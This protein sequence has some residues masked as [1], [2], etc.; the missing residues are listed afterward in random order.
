[1]NRILSLFILIFGLLSI[2]C[3]RNGD[4]K[5]EEIPSPKDKL[6]PQGLEGSTDNKKLAEAN[7]RFSI[8]V[9]KVSAKKNREK[10]IFLSPFSISTA[11][12][13]TYAGAMNDTEKEMAKVL[14]W[15]E[16][17][18]LMHRSMGLIFSELI[19]KHKSDVFK[20]NIAN[21]LYLNKDKKLFS[22]FAQTNKESYAAGLELVDFEQTEASAQSINNWVSE[23]TQK[24]IPNL[25][26]ASDLTGAE[27]VLVNAI[28]FYGTWAN[29]FKE[30]NTQKD[31]FWLDTD[32]AELRDFMQ[33]EKRIGDTDYQ[34]PFAYTEDAD[35]QVLELPYNKGEGS[36]LIF[37][38]QKDSSN[39]GYDL[40]EKIE[41]LDYDNMMSLIGKLSPTQKHILKIK[42]PKWEQRSK[43]DMVQIMVA[44]GLSAP[45]SP[46]ADFSRISPDFNPEISAIIHEAVI[47]VSEKGTKAAASTA[48]ITKETAV[49]IDPES[50]VEFY[51][52]RPF[53]YLIREKESGIILFIGKLN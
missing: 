36:M 6:L 32:R 51:A 22:D 14:Y 39:S 52:D 21:R 23:Q 11:L 9:F 40:A 47:N 19:K 10:S 15:P 1:M 46:Q 53:F 12:A 13:M 4:I 5:I 24:M 31:S 50:I 33:M 28:Y 41:A 49:R 45:F 3:Q 38:P 8:D 26:K 48:V 18:K 7:N 43:S 2:A 29:L 16:N 25:L 34:Y 42:I 44:L 35:W 27:L 20:I 17:S 30:A 37:L